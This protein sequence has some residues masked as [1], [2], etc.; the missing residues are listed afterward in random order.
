MRPNSGTL[1]DLPGCLRL[2][3]R[4]GDCWFSPSRQQRR[5]SKADGRLHPM[6]GWQWLRVVSDFARHIRRT[7]TRDLYSIVVKSARMIEI[8][9][10]IWLFPVER[11]ADVSRERSKDDGPTG[12]NGDSVIDCPQDSVD[13]RVDVVLVAKVVRAFCSWGAICQIEVNSDLAR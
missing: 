5:Y 10:T 11:G 1:W 6:G 7:E 13:E 9:L 3:T 8:V 4:R 2:R 12:L